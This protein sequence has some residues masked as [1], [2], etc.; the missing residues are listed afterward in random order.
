MDHLVCFLPG[1]LALAATGGLTL[2]NAVAKGTLST[3]HLHD[4]TLAKEIMKTCMGMYK[5]TTT[6]LAPE[7]T[8]FNIA[9]PPAPETASHVSPPDEFSSDPHATWRKDFDVH[10]MDRHNLQRP[11]T[12]ESLF[13]MWRITGERKYRDWGW[14][15]F[16]S[17]MNYTAVEDGGGFT[18]LSNANEIPPSTRDN[19]ESFWLVSTR[20][21]TIFSQST[22]EEI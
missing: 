4:L 11:E 20:R 6:G 15:M 17:F 9:D 16:K 13:Y 10:S 12:V 3:T 7:I 14:D 18:S 5:A 21:R 2:K 19:M 1:T 22:E 8:Y